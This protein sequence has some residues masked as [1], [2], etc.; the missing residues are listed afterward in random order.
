MSKIPNTIIGK[1]YIKLSTK[2]LFDGANGSIY[3]ATD[4]K[5]SS[6]VVIKTIKIKS[7]NSPSTNSHPN[8]SYIDG[9]LREFNLLRKCSPC[10]KIIDVYAVASDRDSPE[11]SLIMQFCPHGDVLDYLCNLRHRRV[12][13]RPHLKDYIFKQ[14]V[15]AIDF[16]HR[17]GIAHRDVKPENFLIA[18]NG[19]LKLTDFGYALDVSATSGGGNTDSSN[20]SPGDNGDN[21]D[22][23]D[24]EF[25]DASS[26]PASTASNDVPDVGEAASVSDSVSD[27]VAE[28]TA[29]TPSFKAPELFKLQKLHSEG[30]KINLHKINNKALDM[31]ALGIVYF[32]VFLMT[33][34]WTSSNIYADENKPIKAFVDNYP[35]SENHIKDLIRKLDDR[36][37]PVHQNPALLLFKRLHYDARYVVLRMLNPSPENRCT[38]EEAVTSQW[39][40]Q[41][42]AKS[43]DLIDAIPK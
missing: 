36:N 41:V 7:R 19:G 4:S 17:H 34:P 43:S 14:M 39:L 37:F 13:L 32:Q 21:G 27:C 31:W 16:L 35:L 26:T 40:T 1:D 28:I 25:V 5:Q 23:G 33:V 24:N 8:K 3:R 12:E 18:D 15:A 29:G 22:T 9:V 11:L 38:A 42:Y 10:N 20:D 6:V 2:P 30:H